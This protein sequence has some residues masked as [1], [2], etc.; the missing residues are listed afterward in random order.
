MVHGYADI[1]AATS[2]HITCFKRKQGGDTEALFNVVLEFGGVFGPR[3]P[4]TGFDKNGLP[5]VRISGWRS[6]L[7]PRVICL[8][9]TIDTLM[10]EFENCGERYSPTH[11]GLIPQLKS[12]TEKASKYRPIRRLVLTD[13]HDWP[14]SSSTE[15]YWGRDV[16][17]GTGAPKFG[18]LICFHHL[19][20]LWIIKVDEHV[21]EA[22]C[23]RG[24]LQLFHWEK[25][26]AP[27]CKIP[28]I[29]FIDSV[30]Q[31]KARFRRN[32]G[33]SCGNGQRLSEYTPSPGNR[34]QNVEVKKT[35]ME[36]LVS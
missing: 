1:S 29:I 3:R 8:N 2:F 11:G 14:G 9:T 28:S 13:T 32:Y 26:Q 20:E 7:V 4:G 24:L 19:E 27:E 30:G 17:P 15:M 22:E 5:L 10:V 25:K 18:G 12:L 16:E 6:R 35:M 33:R 34:N 36:R 23:R 21:P 31:M